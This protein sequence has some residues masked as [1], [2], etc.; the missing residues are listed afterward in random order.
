MSR[1]K[2]LQ[3]LLLLNRQLHLTGPSVLD[4]SPMTPSSLTSNSKGAPACH[5][6]RSPLPYPPI[7]F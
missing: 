7:D 6:G 5:R 4:S 2:V 1:G 3:R